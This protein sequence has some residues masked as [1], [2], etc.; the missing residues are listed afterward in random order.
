MRVSVQDSTIPTTTTTGAVLLI[1]T[2]APVHQVL[3][4]NTSPAG[5]TQLSSSRW[6][7][8]LTPPLAHPSHHSKASTSGSALPIHHP[9]RLA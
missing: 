2:K 9:G 5:L 8:P 3:P 4:L 6:S 7:S 1:L